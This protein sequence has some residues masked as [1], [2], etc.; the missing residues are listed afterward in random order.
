MLT[1]AQQYD[2]KQ[3]LAMEE[4]NV[5]RVAEITGHCRNTIARYRDLPPQEKGRPR[6]RPSLIEKEGFDEL[7]KDWVYEDS[8]LPQ[9][10]KLAR[11]V[12]VMYEKL[13]TL[14][15]TGSY[16]TTARYVRKLREEHFVERRTYERLEIGLDIAQMDFGTMTAVYHGELVRVE[17]LIVSLPYSNHPVVQALPAQNQECV[18]H[19]LEQIFRRMGGVPRKIWCDNLKA[20]VIQP[21]RGE[22]PAVLAERFAAFAAHYGFEPVPCNPWSGNEKGN[23]EKKVD[24]IREHFFCMEIPEMQSYEQ[25]TEWLNLELEKRDR[26][27]V[28]YEKGI[29]VMDLFDEQKKGFLGLPAPWTMEKTVELRANKYREVRLDNHR[30]VIHKAAPSQKVRVVL[31]WKGYRCYSPDNRLLQE[32]LRPYY[33]AGEDIRWQEIFRDWVRRP[34]CIEHSRWSKHLPNPI[35]EFLLETPSRESQRERLKTLI[36]LMDSFT[37]EQ[38]E[39]NLY[40]LLA[41]P[42]TCPQSGLN[43]LLQYDHLSRGGRQSHAGAGS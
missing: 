25:L 19:G 35:R 10:S 6:K 43:N 11:S 4:N 3:R 23:V 15:F 29:I 22:K 31:D 12:R 21:K 13:V 16:E 20:A 34:G 2:I 37:L 28:H 40:S 5:S 32:G 33:G 8:L 26:K 41:S 24:F 38:I 27:T 30:V 42:R 9:G 14:G 39:E 17:L 36:E 18:L 1:M 7:L